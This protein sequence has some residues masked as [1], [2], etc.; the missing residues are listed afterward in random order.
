VT[1]PGIT[2]SVEAGNYT[3]AAEF[4]IRT[5]AAIRLAGNILK[6]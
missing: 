2:E 6:T 1:F 5:S 3:L 4:V